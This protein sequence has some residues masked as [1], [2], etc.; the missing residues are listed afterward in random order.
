MNAE[1]VNTAPAPKTPQPAGG[2]RTNGSRKRQAAA[3]KQRRQHSKTV[4]LFFS[5]EE[6]PRKGHT[7]K[8]MRTEH[9]ETCVRVCTPRCR[10]ARGGK[11][12][13]YGSGGSSRTPS[14]VLTD[15]TRRGASNGCPTWSFK[16]SN[17]TFK[18][19]QKIGNILMIYF[20]QSNITKILFQHVTIRKKKRG[21]F[22]Y[23]WHYVT[24]STS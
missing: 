12:S 13:C 23:F 8:V 22:G 16:F 15:T 1:A 19:V 2:R 17:S 20:I 18:K 6:S 7:D 4:S 9:H 24:H 3:W 5:G 11:R 14:P 10:A 21:F